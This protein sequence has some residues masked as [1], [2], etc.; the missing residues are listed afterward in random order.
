MVGFKCLLRLLSETGAERLCGNTCNRNH[1]ASKLAA[2]S[3]QQLHPLPE[4]RT[5]RVT[6]MTSGDARRPFQVSES[7]VPSLAKMMVDIT[8]N[9]G[10]RKLRVRVVGSRKHHMHGCRFNADSSCFPNATMAQNVNTSKKEKK[11]KKT[12]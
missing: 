8:L 9:P 6:E 12:G 7:D 10:V 2:L 4:S 3:S 5:R 1:N 11:K